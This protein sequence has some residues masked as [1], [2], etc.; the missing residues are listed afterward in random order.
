[1]RLSNGISHRGKKPYAAPLANSA[2]S[3]YTCSDTV[4]YGAVRRF[5]AVRAIP[6]M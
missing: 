1:M 4:G 6:P 2:E 5:S 3:V